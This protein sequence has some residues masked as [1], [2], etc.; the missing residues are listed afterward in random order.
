VRP[1][2]LKAYSRTTAARLVAGGVLLVV[3]V[4]GG[5]VYAIYGSGALLS[6]LGCIGLG[7]LPVAIIL[8]VLAGLE[9]L[10]RRADRG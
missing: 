9:A 1:R 6:A 3:V 5:L 2:D 10:R 8:L 4:G 7:L